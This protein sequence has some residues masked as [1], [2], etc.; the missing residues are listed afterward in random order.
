MI[1]ISKTIDIL[2]N[3]NRKEFVM[4]RW[5]V[6]LYALCSDNLAVSVELFKTSLLCRWNINILV[7][8]WL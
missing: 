5:D 8:T 3:F 1:D 2:D 4:F 6:F 7:I